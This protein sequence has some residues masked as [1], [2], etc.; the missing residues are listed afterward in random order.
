MQMRRAIDSMQTIQ[1]R[2]LDSMRTMQIRAIGSMQMLQNT[3]TIL[4][5]DSM[6]MLPN[7]LTISPEAMRLLE[8]L[9]SLLK[10][11]D[12]KRLIFLLVSA[13]GTAAVLKLLRL[14]SRRVSLLIAA[15]KEKNSTQEL[16]VKGSSTDSPE[17][18]AN[19]PADGADSCMMQQHHS[20]DAAERHAH[21]SSQFVTI[22]E[23][24]KKKSGSRV[25]QSL[26]VFESQR[27]QSIPFKV[28]QSAVR[29]K[30]RAG[31]RRRS[32]C[33]ASSVAVPSVALQ[34]QVN[35]NTEA[36]DKENLSQT[37]VTQV[38]HVSIASQ[39]T[40]ASRAARKPRMRDTSAIAV[41]NA[42]IATATLAAT[43]AAATGCEAKKKPAR[44]VSVTQRIIELEAQRG[45]ASSTCD[46]LVDALV[47]ESQDVGGSEVAEAELA[48][49]KTGVELRAY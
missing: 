39:K 20:R 4:A 10:R 40:A 33:I 36:T 3:L 8:T 28:H 21:A 30:E 6:Q 1:I 5:I 14:V 42:A 49:G 43:R 48:H 47:R 18:A 24:G 38:Q 45:K 34:A 17:L 23:T 44:R 32:A 25:R 12:R 22:G 16:C 7:A 19:K 26:L 41:A 15:R 2:A 46:A 9:K 27:A 11:I 37:V 29:A 31:E 13:F 35:F